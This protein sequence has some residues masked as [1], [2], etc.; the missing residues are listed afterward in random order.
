MLTQINANAHTTRYFRKIITV[1]PVSFPLHMTVKKVADVPS[2]AA[3]MICTYPNVFRSTVLNQT[4]PLG[5]SPP[6]KWIAT[7]TVLVP[8][9]LE[10]GGTVQGRQRTDYVPRINCIGALCHAGLTA[11]VISTPSQPMLNL[12]VACLRLTVLTPVRAIF[13]HCL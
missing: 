3:F 4:C 5:T 9:S 11:S 12:Y 10:V 7:E 2:S 1:T 6:E 13:R 8:R